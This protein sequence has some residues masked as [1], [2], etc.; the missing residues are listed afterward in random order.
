MS[1]AAV[2]KF[3]P[4]NEVHVALFKGDKRSIWG[5]VY[6]DRD[7]NVDVI[8]WDYPDLDAAKSA[9]WAVAQ[10]RGAVIVPVRR[11]GARS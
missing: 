2:I 4:R 7:G 6:I 1:A 10:R 5:I 11:M 3:G 8:D 9:A